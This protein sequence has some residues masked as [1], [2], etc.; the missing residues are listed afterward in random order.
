[1]NDLINANLLTVNPTKILVTGGCGFMASNLI[2]YLFRKYHNNIEIVNIDRLDYCSNV[3][4]M[5]VDTCPDHSNINYTFV[6]GDITDTFFLHEFFDKNNDFDIIIHMAAQTHVDNS[7]N[8][9]MRFTID[10]VIGTH[11]MLDLAKNKCTKLK[12]FIHMSTDEVYG[13]VNIDHDGC[14]EETLHNPTNPYSASKAA[15]EM[16]VKSYFSSFKLP[17]IIVRSNNVFGPRQY[18]EKV[19]PKFIKFLLEGKKCTIHGTGESRRNFIFTEDFCSAMDTVMLKGKINEVYN[20]AD[21][22]EFS[23]LDIVRCLVKKLDPNN[24]S[25][26]YM[27]GNIDEYIEYVEDRKFNDYRYAINCDKLHALG[28]KPMYKFDQAM[29]ITIDYYVN[30]F[31]VKTGTLK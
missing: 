11:N 10:N 22:N 4:F 27:E 8:T 2:L 12:K 3:D 25:H 6:Q 28:W 19:I 13:E 16:F 14:T 1:M 15:A 17:V 18:H 26:N 30:K 9:P 21:Q 29:D 5:D 23:V 24:K 20:I 31:V 7:F